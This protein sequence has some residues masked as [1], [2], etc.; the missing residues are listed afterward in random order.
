AAVGV[1]RPFALKQPGEPDQLAVVGDVVHSRSLSLKV[2]S[3]SRQVCAHAYANSALRAA[4]AAVCWSVQTEPCARYSAYSSSA[5]CAEAILASTSAP[6]T[7]GART[8][9]QTRP[10]DFGRLDFDSTH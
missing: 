4:A 2:N 6:V 1:E 9:G 5:D 10:I 3:R 7:S 8:T